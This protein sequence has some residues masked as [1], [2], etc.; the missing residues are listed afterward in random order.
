MTPSSLPTDPAQP[1]TLSY[2]LEALE[3]FERFTRAS[4]LARF[5]T[6]AAPYDPT[7]RVKTWFD[8]SQT[9]GGP[10][11]IATTDP[12]H[13]TSLQRLTLDVTEASSVNLAGS[14]D[15]PVWDPPPA[16]GYW[17]MPQFPNDRNTI[18]RS[19]LCK[20]QEAQALVMEI[21]AVE[22]AAGRLGGPESATQLKVSEDTTAV[23][24]YDSDEDRRV[25]VMTL[26]G[27]TQLY[28]GQLLK[29]RYAFGVGAPGHWMDATGHQ[30]VWVHEL[31]PQQLPDIQ[32]ERPV[33]IRALKDNERIADTP[34]GPTIF[35]TDLMPAPPAGAGLTADQ[36]LL[37]AS[38]AKTV[39][40]IERQM[41][42]LVPAS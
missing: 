7:R 6:Q 21:A 35:R 10:Y 42:Q 19:N 2:S 20:L 38:T 1:N 32:P 41:S 18:D 12:S 36:E 31:G 16:R 26:P 37:L 24:F 9:V 40:L 11:L 15:Y 33:P 30:P 39:T 5:G 22:Q 13:V 23:Y 8:T 28:C 34:F 27:G 25:F 3:L 17:N 14:Y 4:Y 29:W